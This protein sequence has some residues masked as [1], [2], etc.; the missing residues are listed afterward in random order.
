MIRKPNCILQ[1]IASRLS[2]QMNCQSLMLSKF[3]SCIGKKEHDMGPVPVGFLH[4]V[5]YNAL[6]TKVFYLSVSS[7]DNCV[8]N[9]EGRPCLI[10]NILFCGSN[11]ILVVEYFSVVKDFFDCPL[12]SSTVA[13]FLVSHL[14]G[15]Y[16]TL[17]VDQ[18][19]NKFVAMP[20]E[21]DSFIL[22][23]LVHIQ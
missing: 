7:G 3:E 13:V 1:Q 10:R 18:I 8:A 23:P 11:F 4:A 22:V 21:Q 2:E 19:S 15:E 9:K 12:P 17:H 16:K 20:S 5:Q 6:Q 14:A